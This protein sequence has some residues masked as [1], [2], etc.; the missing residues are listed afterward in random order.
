MSYD[1]DEEFYRPNMY[2]LNMTLSRRI[3]LDKKTQ[4][5]SL[6]IEEKIEHDQLFGQAQELWC[7]IESNLER[8]DKEEEREEPDEPMQFHEEPEQLDQE[9]LEW[10]EMQK[11]RKLFES[12]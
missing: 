6:T 7:E 9:E 1:S 5:G 10:I 11:Q 4:N 8:K 12:Y 3:Q 2:I